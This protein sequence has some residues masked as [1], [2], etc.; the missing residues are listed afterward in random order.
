[1]SVL[2]TIQSVLNTVDVSNGNVS[3]NLTDTESEWIVDNMVSFL[4]NSDPNSKLRTN[5]LTKVLIP[6]AYKVYLPYA[7]LG[8]GTLVG[9]GYFIAKATK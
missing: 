3:V 8:V 1:M 7:L 2:D 4:Q 6:C 9:I 5:F